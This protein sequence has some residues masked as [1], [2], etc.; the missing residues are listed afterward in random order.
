VTTSAN[1][2]S[3][4]RP[5][6]VKHPRHGWRYR[7][8]PGGAAARRK[9]TL[10]NVFQEVKNEYYFLKLSNIHCSTGRISHT[11]SRSRQEARREK[12][13]EIIKLWFYVCFLKF[14][15]IG[16]NIEKVF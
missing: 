16:K 3:R 15:K 1:K 8:S 14:G 12:T 9:N 6:N 7:I 4:K 5:E 13:P 2:C 10:V 11:G